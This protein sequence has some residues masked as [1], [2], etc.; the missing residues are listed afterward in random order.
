MIRQRTP[1]PGIPLKGQM[2]AETERALVL[3][4]P[5]GVERALV[6]KVIGRFEECGLRIIGLKMVRPDASSVE[7]HYPA[8]EEWLASVGR[9]TKAALRDAG[10]PTEEDE[11]HIGRRVRGRIV[12]QFSGNL[13][14]AMV[15]QGNSANAVVRK[16]CGPTEP[17]TADASTLRG[18]YSSDT[19]IA[20]SVEDRPIRNMVHASEN[21]E[22]AEN[23]IGI[24]FGEGEIFS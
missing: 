7:R 12:E 8:D 24:W 3:I 20:A 6:G 13:V 15:L 4:K 11:M 2:R 1:G 10:M 16:L 19:F 14:V 18:L 5:D 23:E 22:A 21:K 9:K 17:A